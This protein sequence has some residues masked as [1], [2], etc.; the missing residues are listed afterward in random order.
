MKSSTD[1]ALLIEIRDVLYEILLSSK[2]HGLKEAHISQAIKEVTAA[3][4]EYSKTDLQQDKPSTRKGIFDF[5]L[6][7]TKESVQDHDE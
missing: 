7:E 4:S 3:I 6:D 1:H 5:Y 2:R